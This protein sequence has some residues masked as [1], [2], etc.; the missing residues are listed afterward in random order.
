MMNINF[1]EHVLKT[2]N[3]KN[4]ITKGPQFNPTVNNERSYLSLAECGKSICKIIEQLYNNVQCDYLCPFMTVT[5]K[6]PTTVV[7]IVRQ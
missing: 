2:S 6:Q 7:A 1:T 4:D 5:I 3:L